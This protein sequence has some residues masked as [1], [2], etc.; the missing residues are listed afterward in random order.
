MTPSGARERA[1]EVLCADALAPIVDLVAWPEGEGPERTVV[2]A[3]A[4]GA[5]RLSADGSSQPLHG[6]DPVAV[7]DPMA[8]ADHA[9]VAADPRPANADNA[10]PLAGPRLLSLFADAGRAPDLVVVHTP[11]HYF[12]EQGGH[13]G[14]HG[15]LDAGQSRA[16]LL[17]SGAG[18]EPAG[19]V[20]DWGRVVD[21]GPTLAWLAG[22]DG[23]ALAGLDGRVRHDHVRRGARHV[24]GL[25]WDGAASPDLL[26]LA[27]TG[28]LPNVARLLERGRALRGGAV[29][30]F[31]SVTLCNHTSALTGVGPGRHGVVGNSFLD[32][33]TGVRVNANDT[34][35]WH[36]SAEWFRPGVSTV[37]E[38]VALARPGALTA[39]VDEPVDRGAGYSTMALIRA[40]GSDRGAR[41]LEEHLPDPRTSPHA[42]RSFVEASE[43]YAFWSA[44]DEAGLAQ[45][46]EL[47][48]RPADAPVLTWWSSTLTDAGNHA[49]G[50]GS[51][52]ATAALVDTDRRLGVFLDALDRLGLA[53][54]VTLLLTAD[55]GFEAAD[56]QVRGSW[57]PALR[58]AGIE[59]LDEANGFIY[60]DADIHAGPDKR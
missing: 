41:A 43:D 4:E 58:T 25:L 24:V 28:V 42:S 47:F 37:F 10:Y 22:V 1:V 59:H 27:T 8:R 57:S 33:D 11:A 35:T 49:G 16:P 2:V 6:L 44:V 26:H 32:R 12:P 36:R 52:I 53:D 39:C 45:V 60:L 7:R 3:N 13:L 54:D 46:L 17:L 34:T 48:A 29:A 15:S 40:T 9:E 19:V 21:V 23:E 20:E 18:V 30:E 31:P 38:Q 14:E 5:T 51:A 50:P 55:H 56:P